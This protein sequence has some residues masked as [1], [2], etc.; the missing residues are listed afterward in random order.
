MGLGGRVYTYEADLVL[1]FGI[2]Q[3]RERIAVGHA[4]DLAGQRVRV[5]R[6]AGEC[7]SQEQQGGG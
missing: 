7:E 2:V 1:R 5:L 4:D 3:E 6:L